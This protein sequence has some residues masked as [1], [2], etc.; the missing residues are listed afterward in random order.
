MAIKPLRKNVNGATTNKNYKRTSIKRIIKNDIWCN[1]KYFED[2]QHT[3]VS[4]KATIISILPVGIFK[5]QQEP[6]FIWF[7]AS[8][9]MLMV[10]QMKTTPG[11]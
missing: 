11:E 5:R 9:V 3:V 1:K 6:F 7:D 4:P 10:N 2:F 8:T